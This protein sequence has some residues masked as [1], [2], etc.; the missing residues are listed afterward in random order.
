MVLNKKAT[1]FHRCALEVRVWQGFRYVLQG[2][3]VGFHPC[4]SSIVLRDAYSV[5][6]AKQAELEPVHD[7]ISYI[8]SRGSWCLEWTG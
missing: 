5:F 2:Y 1:I 3:W 8:Y 7:I 4:Y 6:S